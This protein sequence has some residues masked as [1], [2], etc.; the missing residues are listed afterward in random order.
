MARP[1]KVAGFGPDR[2]PS[3][4]PRLGAGRKTA[5]AQGSENVRA[6]DRAPRSV[7]YIY[8][9]CENAKLA[10]RDS[11]ENG[12]E[13]CISIDTSSIYAIAKWAG[14]YNERGQVAPT[15]GP[16]V[17]EAERSGRAGL[18]SRGGRTA[19]RGRPTCAARTSRGASCPRRTRRRAPHRA[20]PARR[21]GGRW[22]PPQAPQIG[23]CHEASASDSVGTPSGCHEASASDSVGTPSG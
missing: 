21:V 7:Q 23:R 5:G 15:S 8:G 11:S 18:M 2:G 12:K 9:Y 16:T 10:W 3:S 13:W 1:R 22:Q 17:S 20:R 4:S 14:R 19:T 6:V